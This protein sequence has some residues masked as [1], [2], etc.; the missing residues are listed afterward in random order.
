MTRLAWGSHGERF[1]EAGVDRGVLYLPGQNGVPWNGLK[2]VNE[3][4]TGG[5]PQPYY[6]DGYKY[7]NVASA[8]EYKATLE[9]Y[10]SPIEF[11]P[12]EGTQ[13]IHNG[14]F[15]TQQ[16]RLPFN[17]SYRTLVGNDAEGVDHGYKIH[18]VY[19]ALAAPAQRNHQTTASGSSSPLGLSWSITT[20]PPKMSG[21]KPTAHFIIDSRFTPY[22]LMIQI[23][24]LLY[25][26]ND[27]EP[28]LP[29]PAEL[30]DM[31]NN[32]VAP[33]TITDLGNGW[34]QAEGDAVS[35]MSSTNFEI[36]DPSVSSP[37]EDG[38]F[39]INY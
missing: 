36:D 33:L 13:G 26:S 3:A 32:Y 24:D 38:E 2:A 12:C 23:E 9:A 31:M 25:G 30:I 21:L 22:G 14:L 1:F 17:L 10:T 16:P 4:P 29:T 15:A 27:N 7:L 6:V 19:N 8:E 5:E 35:M 37:D 28:T 18:L 39:I 11:A 20:T 34:Y